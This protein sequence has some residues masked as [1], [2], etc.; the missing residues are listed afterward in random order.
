VILD[1][2]LPPDI[3]AAE[4]AVRPDVLVVE[5]GEVMIPGPVSFS[6]DIG[7]PPGVA[8][9][10]LAEAALLTMENRYECFTLGRDLH[11]DKVKEIYRLFRRHKFQI[12][13]LR[14][15]GA[16]LTDALVAEKNARAGE[17]RRDPALL[18]RV[19]AVAGAEI[20]RIPP[21]AKGVAGLT[22][23]EK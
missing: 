9:A 3:S 4:A 6:F 22:T 15:F 17:L 11:P 20:A 14:T 18:A 5:S 7:L 1:V 13:P 21:R 10:C 23:L 19:K 16:P 8:Y 12:A 2:A